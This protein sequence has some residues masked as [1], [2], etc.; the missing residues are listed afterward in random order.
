M[1]GV[2]GVQVCAPKAGA[3]RQVLWRLQTKLIGMQGFGSTRCLLQ[4]FLRYE[5]NSLIEAVAL[6]LVTLMC[7][8]GQ[9]AQRHQTVTK[10]GAE[11]A[12]ISE[13][14]KTEML[15]SNGWQRDLVEFCIG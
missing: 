9:K 5:Q 15:L 4:Y 11:Q 12:K 10:I 3:L 1:S 13:L 2:V 7:A 8:R 14:Q 6:E